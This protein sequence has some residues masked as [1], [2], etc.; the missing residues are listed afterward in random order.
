[1][2]DPPHSA[3]TAQAIIAKVLTERPA[4]VRTS[5]PNV[6]PHV[7]AAIARAL[8]KLAADR[9]GTAKE[10]SDA[11]EGK[12]A[13]TTSTTYPSEAPASSTWRSVRVRE[14]AA[15]ALVVILSAWAGWRA[16]RT[17]AEAPVIRVN[18]DL[19]ANVRVQDVIVGTTLAVS[20][21][22]DMI[23]F[24]G[25]NN[26]SYRTYIRRVDELSA[27]EITSAVGRNLT[28]SPD[29]HWLA[30]TEGS[31]LYK[32]SVES[33]QQS[34]VS[35]ATPQGLVY[36]VTWKGMD[37]IYL[38]GFSGLWA[39]PAGGGTVTPVRQDS[40]RKR[41][42]QRWPLVLP[43]GKLLAFA[44]SN[45]SAEIPR[46]SVMT[47]GDGRVTEFEIQAVAPLGMLGDQ[48][49]Y[50]S[51]TG[52]LMAVRFDLGS[53]RP[54]GEPT[55]VDDGVLVDPTGGAKAGL[56]ESG[57]LAYLRGRAQLQPVLVGSSE[58]TPTPI[59]QEPGI[60]S[61]PR[62]SPD[63]GLMA[64][65]AFSG[66][67][68]DIWIRDVARNTFTRLTVEGTNS[69]PEWSTD[70]RYVIFISSRDGKA[71]IW[72]RLADASGPAELV[73]QPE[74]EPFEA[75]MSP[76]SKWLIFRTAP[77]AKYSRDIL[78]VPLTG[79]RTVKPLVT[80]PMSETMMRLSPDGKWLAYQSNESGRTEVYVRPF[81]ESG[82]RITVSDNGATEA[83]WARNGRAL[84]YR[85]PIGEVLKVDVT[86][87][88]RFS[89]GKRRTVLTGNYIT[90][91]SH[92]SYDVA[93]DGRFLMLKRAG[94]EA[95]TI[96]VHNWGRE[97]REKTA[98]K[99]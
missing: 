53:G 97:L 98:P 1:V 2:G 48:L 76:D 58:A 9:F 84:F 43:G 54:T 38:G 66:N 16:T 36:G 26:A 62:L 74:V 21:K 35:T 32:V 65:T 18:F 37:S 63:G 23:A 49:V 7:E 50:V 91:A 40:T 39:V 92:A 29:G 20:P 17:A 46:L 80:G 11:I 57:T 83:V 5:R 22:G 47:L 81:P 25:V 8:E 59:G 34:T 44:G 71:G 69:R 75:I 95:Q 78:A 4:S 68:T 10:F 99:R 24:T 15:W 82:A 45:S 19:P 52:G 73:Y 42:G 67:A 51:P 33:G 31:A 93:P 60:Y 86:T 77:G 3:S 70:G 56:S 41:V 27:R 61:Y 64:I 89:I 87:G 79:E 96:V 12:G 90:D 6:A 30:F 14:L 94:A 13:A 88:A 85:G 55:Q 72:R 28:F